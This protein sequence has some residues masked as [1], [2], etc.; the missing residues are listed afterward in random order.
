MLA[1]GFVV[2]A[3]SMFPT[4]RVSSMGVK[5]TLS[6]SE[7]S[8]YSEDESHYPTLFLSPV[9]HSHASEWNR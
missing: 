7:D 1:S 2:M 4:V 8:E 6:E 3:V 9:L 5:R